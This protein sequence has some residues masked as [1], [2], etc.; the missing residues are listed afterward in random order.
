MGLSSGAHSTIVGDGIESFWPE[1]KLHQFL[2]LNQG[3][4]DHINVYARSNNYLIAKVISAFFFLGILNSTSKN[5][6]RNP[7]IREK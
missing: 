6:F 1:V 2:N 3:S 7:R 4:E 5:R